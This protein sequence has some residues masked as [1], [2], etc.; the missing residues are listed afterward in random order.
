MIGTLLPGRLAKEMLVNVDARCLQDEGYAFRGVGY[1]SSTLLQH[2]VDHYADRV[3]LRALVDPSLPDMAEEHT[4]LFEEIQPWSE[5]TCIEQESVF[6]QLSPMTHDPAVCGRVLDRKG[7]LAAAVIYDFIPLDVSERYLANTESLRSYASSML[8]LDAYQLFFPISLYSE[9][10][11]LET[12]AAHEDDTFVTGVTLRKSFQDGM[13]ARQQTKQPNKSFQPKLKTGD[14]PYFIFVGGGDPRKNVELVVTAHAT[15]KT[16]TDL[17]IV[18]NYQDAG[19]AALKEKHRSLGGSTCRIRFLSGISDDELSDWYASSIANISSSFIEGF[20]LPVIEGMAAGAPTLVSDNEAHQE[21]VTDPQHRFDPNSSQ[22]LADLMELIASDTSFR[23]RVAADQK[24][25]PSRFLGERVGERFWQPIFQRYQQHFGASRLSPLAV[26]SGERRASLAILS[27]F[28]SERSGVADYTRKS[29][30]ALAKHLEVDVFT[31]CSNPQPTPEVRGFYP[32]S[33]FA[34]ISGG[35]DRV[36]SVI[37]NSSFHTKIIELQ[38]EHGGPCLV[39]DNRLAEL[40]H[41]WKGEEYFR[42]MAC[43]MLGREV[44]IH[45]SQSWISDPGK[46]PGIFFDE[47]I[48]SANPLIVHSRGIQR[49]I[50]KQYNIEAQ[51]LPFSCYRSFHEEQLSTSSRQLARKSLGFGD[52]AFHVI[53]LG[54]VADSKAPKQCIEAISQVNLAGHQAH[55]HFVGSSSPE[56]RDQLIRWAETHRI[57]ANVHFTNEWVSEDD[58]QNYVLAADFA[59]QLRTHFFGGLSGALLDCIVSGLPTV[60]ND[61]LAE[62][63]DCPEY[64]G[65]ISDRLEAEQLSAALIGLIGKYGA[66]YRAH[67]SRQDY[68]KRHS[69]DQYAIEMLRVLGLADTSAQPKTKL[70]A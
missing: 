58:Y 15:S 68:L 32:I 7:I 8:W 60:S 56:Q 67:V 22:A 14:R 31:D 61:D 13:L 3:R 5:A 9:R 44:P 12:T 27:P 50:K 1:H 30:L 6:V 23:Q 53:T 16:E 69:F 57:A 33:D 38:R 17:V 10:R 21:L 35:Y 46:L 49:Q 59:V 29:V 24:E 34:Y 54:I 41:W 28:P 11:L 19:K 64:I 40:Y 42:Q 37:G 62:A 63:M 2:A 39:H 55:L 26:H 70:I 45:E 51:Y 18:G 66:K 20:S 43:R 47:L 4:A 65:R 36:L 48:D 52:N 25:V